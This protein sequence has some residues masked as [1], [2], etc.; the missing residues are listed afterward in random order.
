MTM[1]TLQALNDGDATAFGDML[2]GVFENAPWVAARAAA[3]RPFA[4]VTALH[5]A[6][7]A[8]VR[9]AGPEERLA[10]LRGHPELAPQAMADPAL[11]AESRAEQG[12][13][14]LAALGAQLDRFAAGNRDYAARFG[15]PFILC[16]RRHTPASVLRMLE[17]RLAGTSAAEQDAALGEIAFISRLRLVACVTG[18]GMPQVNGHLSTHVLD[19]ARGRPARGVHVTLLREGVPIREGTTDADG[20]TGAALIDDEPLR[21]GRYE[22]RF[23]VRACFADWPVVADLPWYDIIPVRFAIAEP[24]GHYHMP[25]LVGPWAYT[26]YRGS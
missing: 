18:P 9:A 15:F 4:T 25:L 22:L 11:T 21:I 6:L 23:D 2:T 20:R 24:E 19:T 10:F 16:V 17:A 26:T 7:M 3:R 14:G 13:L 8:A 12:G 5:E 1:N